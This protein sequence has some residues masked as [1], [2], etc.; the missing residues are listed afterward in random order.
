MHNTH[1]HSS[2]SSCNL[3]T[4]PCFIAACGSCMLV[5]SISPYYRHYRLLVPQYILFSFG[6]TYIQEGSLC[7]L[8][9]YLYRC[10]VLSYF[11]MLLHTQ[12]H[13]SSYGL[14]S[15]PHPRGAVWDLQHTANAK[16]RE[17][18]DVYTCHYYVYIILS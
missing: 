13:A 16:W 6:G 15:L 2:N 5:V 3:A 17:L 8:P 12:P 11:P 14:R 4:V 7:F 10:T 9:T 1:T 18:I